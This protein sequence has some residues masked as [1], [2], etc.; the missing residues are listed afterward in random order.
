VILELLALAAFVGLVFFRLR[1]MEEKTARPAAQVRR[2]NPQLEQ[3]LAYAA[4]LYA[5]HKY[6]AA[7][8]AYLSVLKH[9][10]K[11]QVAYMHL[12][13]I[14]AALG[15][16]A[17]S[18]ECFR[19]VT[20]LAPTAKSYFNLG[21]AYYESKNYTRAAAAFEKSV[22]FEPS[23]GRLS[24][25]ARAYQKLSQWPKAVT[26]LEQAVAMQSDPAHMSYL[27]DAY[28][29]QGK[30]AEAA[31]IRKRMQSLGKPAPKPAT[32]ANHGLS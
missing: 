12:G 6:L 19:I 7:E 5:E 27:Y 26:A 30:T 17:D 9:D 21:T 3:A 29:H 1:Q 11:N 24:A 15:N 31:A 23:A 20:Q 25:L 28:V 22:A 10:H 18:I 13:K 14:Y 32:T 4:R 8:K 16:H 2:V